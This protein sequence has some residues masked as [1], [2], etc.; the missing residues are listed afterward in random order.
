MSETLVAQTSTPKITITNGVIVLNY[1]SGTISL[2]LA[3]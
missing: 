2:T 3:K 1:T